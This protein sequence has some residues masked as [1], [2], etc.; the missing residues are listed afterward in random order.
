MLVY[1]LCAARSG[2]HTQI[3]PVDKS[4]D[5]VSGEFLS[6]FHDVPKEFLFFDWLVM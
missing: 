6:K 2:H 3:W 1:K 4:V 5:G